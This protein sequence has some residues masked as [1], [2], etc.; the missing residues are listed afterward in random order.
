MVRA[1]RLVRPQGRISPRLR[2]LIALRQVS[3]EAGKA[4][5]HVTVLDYYRAT[6]GGTRSAAQGRSRAAQGGLE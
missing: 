6:D 3:E 4:C 2:G 1:S 5:A